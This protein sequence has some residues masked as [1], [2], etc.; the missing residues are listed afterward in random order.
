MTV[1]LVYNLQEMFQLSNSMQILD[2]S[3]NPLSNA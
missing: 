2:K 3:K 1:V